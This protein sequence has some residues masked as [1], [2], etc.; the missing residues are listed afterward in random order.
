MQVI[1]LIEK[2]GA[3][4]NKWQQ[5]NLKKHRE[6][7]EKIKRS[8]EATKDNIPSCLKEAFD[9]F[10]EINS[11]KAFIVSKRLLTSD[12]KQTVNQ[13]VIECC[14]LCGPDNFSVTDTEKKK[15]SEVKFLDLAKIRDRENQRECLIICIQWYLEVLEKQH[16]K[17]N[18]EFSK[19]LKQILDEMRVN[20]NK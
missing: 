2:Q 18:M 11:K 14:A 8:Y 15:K 17:K 3:S 12:Q 1:Q 7:F 16:Q 6:N 19:K 20:A 4:E 13:S 5:S 10:A 9:L